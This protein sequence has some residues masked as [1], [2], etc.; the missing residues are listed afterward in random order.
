MSKFSKGERGAMEA[1][2]K[3]LYDVRGE[4]LKSPV[5]VQWMEEAPVAIVEY[6]GYLKNEKAKHRDRRM[7]IHSVYDGSIN[8]LVTH[9]RNIFP[10]RRNLSKWELIFTT[11][12]EI[13]DVQKVIAQAK[14]E[15]VFSVEE[16][17][18]VPQT[19][20]ELPITQGTSIE[21]STANATEISENETA[22]EVQQS[23]ES[24]NALESEVKSQETAEEVVTNDAVNKPTG[25]AI[26]EPEQT[27]FDNHSNKEN[28]N[29]E[30]KEM[31]GINELLGAANA[32]AGANA[33]EEQ[34]MTGASNVS[35]K[36]ASDESKAR[37]AELLSESQAA[38]S[39][40]TRENTVSA[41]IVTQAPAALRVVDTKG[42]PTSESD[43]T[44]AAEEVDKKFL[45]FVA[46][47][48]GKQ[49]LTI[50][51]FDKLDD[52][53]KYA[54]VVDK[55]NNMAKAKAMYDLY[56]NMKQNP[57][58]E[59][60]AFIPGSDKVNY[61]IKGY[62]IDSVPYSTDEFIVQLLDNG[63]GVLYGA[64][65]MDK[66]GREIDSD[67]A[68]S[69]KVAIA[70]KKEASK[71][72][73]ITTE[74]KEIQ[75]PIIRPKN[76]REFLKDANNIKYLF[77]KESEEGLGK[78]SFKAAINVDGERVGATV[79]VYALDDK[80]NRIER[81]NK[82]RKADE[83][84]AYKTKIA[85]CSVSVP[86]KKI[87]KE[88]E[89]VFRGEGDIMVCAN[90]WG[91]QMTVAA[92]KG[93]FGTITNVSES[94]AFDIFANIFEGNMTLGSTFKGSEVIKALKS[95]ADAQVAA[96]AAASADELV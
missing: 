32:A 94:P 16:T 66:E 75:V 92:Q 49:G 19:T 4:F 61:P 39:A 31:S 50:E 13:S 37:V 9:L 56:K 18:E 87:V 21:D 11:Y 65:S 40:W 54:N 51:D 29:T 42:V 80:G 38:R 2:I 60:A 78:A 73:G 69:F 88:F 91:I 83:P 24:G 5:I 64:G 47:V 41:V 85:S 27:L 14:T 90:R 34:K 67:K 93:D 58:G 63:N 7:E 82:N 1:A 8:E 70:R 25:S 45:K 84:V 17:K 95:A 74:K 15:T 86:V 96:E 76:K 46:L 26:T 36:K 57:T 12:S 20:E 59:Y 71:A 62:F 79:A 30:V 52:A 55:G 44:K 43:A 23:V 53:S 81:E 68:V 22:V 48:S 33:A 89:A 77:T 10:D 28:T 6:D 35:S 72:Q 3:R